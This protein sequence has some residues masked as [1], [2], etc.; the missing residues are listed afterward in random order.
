MPTKTERLE[1]RVDEA[2]LQRLDDWRRQ[3]PDL[4]PRA[5]AVR[6]LVEVALRADENATGAR[7]RGAKGKR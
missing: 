2:F 7:A 1:L 4:P 5:R 3:Q 6:Q